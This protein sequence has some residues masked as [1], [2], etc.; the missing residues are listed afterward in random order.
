[1]VFSTE[2][3]VNQKQ[4]PRKCCPYLSTF[5]TIDRLLRETET[6]HSTGPEA[7]RRLSVSTPQLEG[8]VMIQFTDSSSANARAVVAELDVPHTMV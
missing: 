8:A 7:G 6:F 4:C 2:Y 1:M 5:P 3:L